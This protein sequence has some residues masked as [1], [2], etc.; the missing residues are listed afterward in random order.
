MAWLASA[1][2]GIVWAIN[3]EGEA[4]ILKVGT[5]TTREYVDNIPNGWTLVENYEGNTLI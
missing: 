5:I 4:W 1:E 3:P 2:E